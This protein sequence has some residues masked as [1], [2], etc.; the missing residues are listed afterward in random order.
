[1]TG[2]PAVKAGKA[3]KQAGTYAGVGGTGQA[4]SKAGRIMCWG[5]AVP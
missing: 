1:M 5:Q 2:Q 3:V 4:A